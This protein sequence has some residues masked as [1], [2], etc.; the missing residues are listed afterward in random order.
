[1]FYKRGK[2]EKKE[3]FCLWGWGGGGGRGNVVKD[4]NHGEDYYD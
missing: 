4:E 1:M 2:G 3:F